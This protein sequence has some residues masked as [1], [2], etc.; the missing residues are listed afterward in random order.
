MSIFTRATV[1]N[2]FLLAKFWYVLQVLVCSR[3]NVQKLHRVFAVFIWQS[4]CESVRRDNLFFSR[5]KGGLSLSHVFVKKVVSRFM[6]LREQTNPFLRAVIQTRLP[7]HLPMF[8][9]SSC[10]LE[11]RR[12]GGFLREVIDAYRFLTIRFSQEYLSCVSRKRLTRDI[13]ESVFP[14][15]VYRALFHAGPG[16]DV[17]SRVKK[18]SIAP[19]IKTFFFKLHKNCLPVKTWLDQRNIFVPWGTHCFLCKKPETIEHVF[20]DSWDALLFWDVL[21]RP[22]K[23]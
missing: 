17:L 10:C 3:I 21:Q 9:V 22:I 2:I 13:I 19:S 4:E 14:M 12:I 8:V 5:C 18:M 6:F 7:E 23:K 16:Q 11:Q 20:L 15:P 1:C